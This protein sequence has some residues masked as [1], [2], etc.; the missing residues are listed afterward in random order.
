MKGILFAHV[1]RMSL[2]GC[3]SIG[4]VLPARLLLSRCGRKYAYW[5]WLAVFLNLCLPWSV[6]SPVSLI[7]RQVTDF[8][9]IRLPEAV[10]VPQMTEPSENLPQPGTADGAGLPGYGPYSPLKDAD[11]QG[12]DRQMLPA[13]MPFSRADMLAFGQRVWLIGLLLLAAYNILAAVRLNWRLKWDRV[14]LDKERGIARAEGFDSPFLWGFLHPVIYLPDGMEEKEYGYV[15][16]HEECHRRRKD[17]LVKTAVFAVT[18]V[19]WF[20]PLVWLAYSLCCRDMEI[21]CDEE[22]L[23]RSGKNICRDYAHSLLK[24]AAKQNGYVMTPLTFGEPSVKSRIKNVLKFHRRPVLLSAAA[25]VCVLAVAAG[26]LLRPQMGAGADAQE[27]QAAA[28]DESGSGAGTVSLAD[29]ENPRVKNNGGT[30]IEVDGTPYYLSGYRLY[31]EGDYLYAVHEYDDGSS[32]VYRHL[33]EGEGYRKLFDGTIEDCSPDGRTLYCKVIEDGAD[34]LGWYDTQTE[35]LKSYGVTGSYLGKDDACLYAAEQGTD[36]QNII[37]IG[38]ADGTVDR[39]TLQLYTT[40]PEIPS[41][42]VNGDDLV[43]SAGE[44]EGSAGYF[45]GSFYSYN[46]KTGELTEKHLTDDPYFTAADG[47]LYY[48]KYS[49]QGDEDSQLCRIGY[50]LENEETVGE[51]LRFLA[52]RAADGMILA[53]K[54]VEDGP[55]QLVLMQPDGSGERVIFDMENSGWTDG[56]IRFADVNVLDGYIS[57]KAQHWQYTEESVGWRSA[58]TEGK[59]YWIA[60]DGS[61]S[62]EWDPNGTTEDE[63]GYLTAPVVG[64]SCD[65]AEAG[66]DLASLAPAPGDLAWELSNPQPGT[67]DNIYLLRQGGD[68]TVYCRGD[69]RAMLVEH[70]GA[71]AEVGYPFTSNYTMLPQF[72]EN[73]FDN[74]GQTEMAVTFNVKHG[75]GVYVDTFLMADP[76]GDG[77]LYVYQFLEEEFD[78]FLQSHLTWR[79]TGSGLQAFVDGQGAGYVQEDNEEA[80]WTKVSVGTQVRFLYENGQ[81]YVSAELEFW[82]DDDNWTVPEYNCSD[83]TAPLVYED[84]GV[85]LLGGCTSRN[86]EM[87]QMITA[88]LEEYYRTGTLAQE[89][90][91]EAGTT[92]IEVV[93][94][95]YDSSKMNAEE[96]TVTAVVRPA[97]AEDYSNDY[98]LITLRRKRTESISGWEIEEILREK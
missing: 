52:F 28:E 8:A 44:Y 29:T 22:V 31:S 49:N 32:S 98:D 59:Y 7:P 79:R 96:L 74:D 37:R 64:R 14:W 91:R 36:R 95:R 69:G 53:Q 25:F 19:H 68:Y 61:E 76:A 93:E 13:K 2:I 83:I 15:L 6:E 72:L 92:D 66:W 33:I 35:E 17:H 5:L 63:Y 12:A 9:D 4:I 62:R 18:A 56:D 86:R 71:Y 21:S 87:E 10:T 34:Y 58:L 54:R 24:Y 41:F 60:A 81:V 80:S 23:S 57:V 20:N 84:R 89:M 73:D 16:A 77:S 50:D 3:Y 70:D 46:M 88:E 38:I 55:D 65:P 43:Y 82:P 48:E 94:F 11:P 42:A 27:P 26:L 97:G 75:T 78:T 1:L 39:E 40:Y 51:D 47:S 45:Y 67:E 85:F 90:M 30:L